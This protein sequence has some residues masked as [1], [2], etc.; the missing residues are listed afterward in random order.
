MKR[1]LLTTAASFLFVLSASAAGPNIIYI[2]ADD[3]GVGDVKAYNPDCKF[4]TPNLDRLAADGMRFTDAH[5]N[6]S[7]CTPTRYGIMTGRYCWRT[8]KKRGVTGGLSPHLINPN[9]ETVASLLKKQGYN[10]ACIGKWHLGMD[11]S[12]KDGT[13]ASDKSS[14]NMVDLKAKIKQGPNEIGFNY[15]FGMSASANHSPHCFIENGYVQG[16]LEVL[17]ENEKKAAGIQGKPGLVAKGFKQSEILPTFTHRTCE[18]VKK[19]VETNP[20]QPF[21]V[22]MPLNSPHSPIVPSAKFKGKSGLSPHGDFCM[23]TDW[24]VGEVINTVNRLGITDNTIIIFTA[25]NGSSP[26]AKFELMQAQGHYP[27]FIYRGLKGMTWEGGHRVPFIVRWPVVVKACAVSEQLICTTDLMATIAEVNGVTLAN[28]VGEDSVSFLPALKGKNV[29]GI[30]KRGVVHHSDSGVFAMRSGKW[31]LLLDDVGGSRRS[32]PKDKPIIDSADIILFDMENDERETKNL[33]QK[34]PQVVE[35][36]KKQL[37]DYVNNGRSTSGIPEPNDTDG[38]S[39]A[40]L[41]PLKD[42]LNEVSLAEM[43]TKAPQKAKNQEKKEQTQPEEQRPT[44][45]EVKAA[46]KAARKAQKANANNSK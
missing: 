4:P 27:S 46:R 24:A 17:G 29:S 15:F 43:G 33:S 14:Q 10:T 22:Y 37:A 32:N 41:W 3:M 44:A 36:M 28:N 25:D 11:W 23:E 1:M 6:S 39:W 21:F 40:E 5:S 18:W 9:R 12:L 35:V 20:D 45:E 2:L 13:I 38:K 31:K 26:M 42:Y 16:E 7:V 8:S 19:Q 34:Y 30:G